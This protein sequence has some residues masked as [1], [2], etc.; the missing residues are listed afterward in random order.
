MRYLYGNFA[1]P[2]TDETLGEQ[3]ISRVPSPLITG[4][5]I[6]SETTG[7]IEILMATAVFCSPN[8][9]LV[10]PSLRGL[11]I[12]VILYDCFIIYLLLATVTHLKFSDKL[13]GKLI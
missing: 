5:H 12:W 1:M 2:Q 13:F 10:F 7:I 8:V 11:L 3:G 4:M 6:P 9:L